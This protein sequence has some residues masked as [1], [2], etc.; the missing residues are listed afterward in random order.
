MIP[1]TLRLTKEG[2]LFC[3]DGAD[4]TQYLSQSSLAEAIDGTE[5]VAL[6]R[7]K[8]IL[9]VCKEL[10]DLRRQLELKRAVELGLALAA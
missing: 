2:N 10:E 4:V 1:N 3:A 7:R 8:D 6:L 9:K 5:A